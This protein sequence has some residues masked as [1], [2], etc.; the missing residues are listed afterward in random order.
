MTNRTVFKS[1]P[2]GDGWIVTRDDKIVAHYKTQKTAERETA[3]LC[4]A[5]ARK[6]NRAVAIL[7]KSDG[8]PKK[9]R[10]YSKVQA[11]WLGIRI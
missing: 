4:R 8:T 10:T 1:H 11:P 3:R 5:E 2:H 9:E 7:H 6:G